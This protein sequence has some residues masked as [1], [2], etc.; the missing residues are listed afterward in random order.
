MP[1]YELV[2]PCII[3]QF[4]TSYSVENGL[5]ATKELWNNLS[6]LIT[7][8][9]PELIVTFQEGGNLHHYKITEK[10]ESGTKNATYTIKDYNTK[11]SNKVKSEF[12]NE[13]SSVKSNITAQLDNQSGGKK[14]RYEMEN[15]SSSSTDS[16]STEEG[17]DYYDFSR[18][19]RLSQPIAYWWYTPYLYRVTRIY[20]PTFNVPLVPYIRTWVP[21]Y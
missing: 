14:K 21:F 1:T 2:N 20:T 16:S 19:K 5:E 12:L 17:A 9:L 11:I 15:S 3:G 7:N 4:K 6:P 18:Y 8:N 13:V 10:V